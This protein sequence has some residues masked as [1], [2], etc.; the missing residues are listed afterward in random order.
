MHERRDYYAILG[1]SRTASATEIKAAWRDV[2]R[3]DHPDQNADPSSVDR[4]K[5]AA[6]AWRV[7]GDPDAR[8]QYDRFG[9]LPDGA[10]YGVPAPRPTP[11]AD[12]FR[13]AAD[14]ARR[15][16]RAERGETLSLDIQLTFRDAARGATRVFELPRDA[17]APG[18]EPRIVRRRL[19]FRIPSG[20]VDGQVLRWRGEGAPG[21][22]GGRDGDLMI[23]CRVASHPWLKRDGLD[24]VGR[25]P[26]RM[27]E[28]IAGARIAAPGIDGPLYLDVP[29]GVRP[30]ERIRVRGAGIARRDGQRGDAIYIVEFELPNAPDAGAI[31]ALRAWEASLSASSTP[32]RTAFDAASEGDA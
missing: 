8:R 2:A 6:E 9:R 29:A 19:E 14:A 20:V 5:A 26:L 28:A 22:W 21:R 31:E 17:A 3:R 23:T 15:A 18:E 11:V 25:L 32:A 16:F 27:S 4:F 7:L 30:G 13:T 10:S 12:A 1:V 24:V